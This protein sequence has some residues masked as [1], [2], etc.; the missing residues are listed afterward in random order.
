GGAE[1]GRGPVQCPTTEAA[2]RPGALLRRTIHDLREIRDIGCASDG[3]P[4]RG[5]SHPP[6]DYRRDRI[7]GGRRR[8]L[9]QAWP[10]CPSGAA[11]WRYQLRL[12]GCGSYGPFWVCS[13]GG[14]RKR[15]LSSPRRDPAGGGT[16]W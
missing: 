8:P 2:S 5:A 10:A 13:H 9:G 6:C 16:D 3:G 14:P 12:Y 7:N 11:G 4:G 15:N 1:W